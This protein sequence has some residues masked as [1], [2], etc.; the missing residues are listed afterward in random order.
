MPNVIHMTYA[1]AMT[2]TGPSPTVRDAVLIPV[3]LTDGTYI[4]GPEVIADPAYADRKA[5]LQSFPQVDYATLSALV[6]VQA[7]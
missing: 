5:L 3:M 7:M 6:P 1:Q 2:V 4:V